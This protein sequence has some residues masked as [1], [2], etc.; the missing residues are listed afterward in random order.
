MQN[1]K[2]ENAKIKRQ[3]LIFT[4]F[5][6]I[7]YYFDCNII[8]NKNNKFGFLEHLLLIR[9]YKSYKNIGGQTIE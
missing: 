1:C 4:I 7:R 3:S 9:L 2:C 8:V 6:Q 5:E